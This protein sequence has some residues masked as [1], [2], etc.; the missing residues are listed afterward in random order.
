MPSIQL[1]DIQTAAEKKYGNLT[2]D[3]GDKAVVLRNPMRLSK[4]ERKELFASFKSE[5]DDET[6]REDGE[7][8]LDT[9][10]TIVAASKADAKAL[11]AALGD[12]LPAKAEVVAEYMKS[13]QVGEASASQN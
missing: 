13:A 5:D 10:L 2:I 9:V 1:S 7:E 8:H 6:D 12:D 4:A 11:L 3:I